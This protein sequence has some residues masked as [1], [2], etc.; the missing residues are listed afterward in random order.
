MKIGGPIEERSK[1]EAE[2]EKNNALQ[3]RGKEFNLTSNKQGFTI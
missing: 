2:N 3:T 1:K